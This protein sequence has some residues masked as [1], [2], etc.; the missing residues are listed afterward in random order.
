MNQQATASEFFM[1]N[2]APYQMHSCMDIESQHSHDYLKVQIANAFDSMSCQSRWLR[3]AS[4]INRLSEKQLEYLASL[5]GADHVGWCATVG[6][7]DGEKGIGMARYVKL[8]KEENVAE[9]SLSVVDEF[10]GQGIGRELLKKL[11]ET[12]AEHGVEIL[13]GYVLLSNR[14][15]LALCRRFGADIQPEDGSSVRADIRVAPHA[16]ND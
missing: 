6:T 12:A 7:E 2:G 1:K 16:H 4:P 13:R 9:F 11:L 14:P 8:T 3:F 10:Q 15:M 5:D